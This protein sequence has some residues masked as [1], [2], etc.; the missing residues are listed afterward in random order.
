MCRAG[1]NILIIPCIEKFPQGNAVGTLTSQGPWRLERTA[2]AAER[3]TL[4]VPLDGRWDRPCAVTAIL[5]CGDEQ[6][7]LLLQ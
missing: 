7:W 3:G 5:K 4:V 2:T 6:A 1:A